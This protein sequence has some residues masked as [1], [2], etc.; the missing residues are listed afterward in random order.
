MLKNNLYKPFTNVSLNLPN[1]ALLRPIGCF[2]V[3]IPGWKCLFSLLATAYFQ[4]TVS[5]NLIV[6]PKAF[7]YDL[8]NSYKHLRA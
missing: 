6:H 8:F 3:S 2:E 4:N 5:L 7:S 1:K